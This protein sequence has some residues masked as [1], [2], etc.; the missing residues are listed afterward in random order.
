[1][2]RVPDSAQGRTLL[3][4]A[5]VVVAMLA[6]WEAWVRFGSSVDD[7]PEAES[8]AAI[9]VSLP[10]KEGN[11]RVLL[12]GSSRVQLGINPATLENELGP[13]WEAHNL[14]LPRGSSARQLHMIRDSIREGDVIVMGVF[15]QT[16]YPDDESS[17]LDQFEAKLPNTSATSQLDLWISVTLQDHLWF[18]RRK[19]SPAMEANALLRPLVVEPTQTRSAQGTLRPGKN[20]WLELQLQPGT[21]FSADYD[22]DFARRLESSIRPD[23]AALFDEV[24]ARLQADIAG[25]QTS[26]AHAVFFVRM[27]SDHEFAV[28]EER[29]YPRSEYWGKLA[30]AY[31]GNCWH[32]ADFAETRELVTVDG[33]HLAGPDALR[34]SRWLGGQ[35]RQAL[36][37]DE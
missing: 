20:G 16:F 18:L 11:R 26:G 4:A 1:M 23:R 8:V 37:Q 34:Y 22:L 32:F 30:S 3:L 5:C 7:R 15:P 21:A 17:E 31:R 24:L 19:T 10:A 6:G 28:V 12:L 33:S 27:P 14:A 13:G 9:N 25:A 29:Y 35:L 2:A 36:N